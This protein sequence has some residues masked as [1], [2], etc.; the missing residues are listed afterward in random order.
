MIDGGR[1]H[2]L[3]LGD[4]FRLFLENRRCDRDLALAFESATAGEHFVEQASEAEDVAARVGFVSLEDFGRHEL[5]GADDRAL[6]RESADGSSKR[7]QSHSRSGGRECSGLARRARTEERD[8]LGQAEVQ[9]LRARCREHDVSRFQV[10]M[11]DTGAVRFLQGIA[12]LL[13]ALQRLFQRE[14]DPSQD[15]SRDSRL[16]RTP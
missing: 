9:Q 6:L 5:E 15:E 3:K 16:A 7:R 10:A 1:S 8:W 11:H 4:W 12:D 14:A 2:R 13:A